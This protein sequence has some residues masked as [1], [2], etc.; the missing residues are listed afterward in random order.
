VKSILI[1]DD[2][3]NLR[4]ILGKILSP[5][6]EVIYSACDGSEG[7]EKYK[8]LKPD[9]VTMDMSMPNCNGIEALKQILEID[10]LAKVMM[11][12]TVDQ[13]EQAQE[14]IA[15]G[16]KDYILKPFSPDVVI[17]RI[18]KVLQQ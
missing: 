16:A 8:E 17:S 3:L 11:I 2:M 14:L 10:P 7:V 13:L 4:V 6:F 9:L 5:E 12:T 18:K 15:L 1:V